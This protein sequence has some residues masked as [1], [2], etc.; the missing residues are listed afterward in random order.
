MLDKVAV[1]SATH[2]A[3]TLVVEAG[4]SQWKPV[5]AKCLKWLQ[6]PQRFC[7]RV[8]DSHGGSRK[9]KSALKDSH[10]MHGEARAGVVPSAARTGLHPDVD[11]AS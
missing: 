1:V 3:P 5:E 11:L 4:G 8:C 9:F 6:I 10:P 7:G 2:L